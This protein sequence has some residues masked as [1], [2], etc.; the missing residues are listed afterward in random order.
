[1]CP[2]TRKARQLEKVTEKGKIELAGQGCRNVTSH[3]LVRLPRQG[4]KAAKVMGGL[5][6]PP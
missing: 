3:E 6:R 2:F 5:S 4:S 1:M